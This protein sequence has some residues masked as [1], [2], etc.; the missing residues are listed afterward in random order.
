[1]AAAAPYGSGTLAGCALLP[2]FS[3]LLP[4]PLG[5]WRCVPCFFVLRSSALLSLSVVGYMCRETASMGVQINKNV[6]QLIYSL[7]TCAVFS[8]LQSTGSL[9]KSFLPQRGKWCK[10]MLLSDGVNICIAT[11]ADRRACLHTACK[12][13]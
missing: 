2:F 12:R 5:P 11:L 3:W 6:M 8:N 13:I 1:M 10:P 9:H 4:R 7:F